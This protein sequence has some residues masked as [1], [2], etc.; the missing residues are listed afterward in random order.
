[1]VFK[2]GEVVKI[3]F[4]LHIDGWPVDTAF[5]V[6][7]G[8]HDELLRA[9]E[10]ALKSALEVLRER[11]AETTLSEVGRA[12]ENAIRGRGFLPI[13]NL[14]GHQMNRWILHAGRSIYNYD[15]GSREKLGYGIFAIEPFATDGF[16]KVKEGEKSSIYRLLSPKPQRLP[17]LRKLLGEIKKFRTFPFSARWVSSPAYLPLLVK[18]GVLHNYPLL[19]EVKGGV[20]SQFEETV[21]IGERVKILTR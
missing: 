2:E 17:Q 21:L 11:G 20:V 7:L 12:I 10:D 18:Q 5:T 4:G 15:C 1:M 8:E 6:D 16:G 3:D 13:T 19:I 9:A 14:T